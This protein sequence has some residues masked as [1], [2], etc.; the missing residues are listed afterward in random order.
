VH[1][2]TESSDVKGASVTAA[3]RFLRDPFITDPG[4]AALADA[5]VQLANPAGS[6]RFVPGVFYY[7]IPVQPIFRS[8]P[9]YA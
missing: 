1:K 2:G 7:K 4:D 8:Y 6:P 3:G 5:E 9:V